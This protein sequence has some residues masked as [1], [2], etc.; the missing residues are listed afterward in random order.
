MELIDLY[1][2]E[3][4]K[5]EIE[6]KYLLETKIAKN[7]GLTNKQVLLNYGS[8][9][10]LLLFFGAHSAWSLKN[11]KRQLKVLLDY[12][13]YFFTLKQLEEWPISPIFIK[14][15]SNFELSI[16]RFIKG[17]NKNNPDIIVVTTPNNPTGKPFSDE[18]IFEVINK[19]PSETLVLIDRSC[20]NYLPEISSKEILN[21]FKTKKIMVMHS[22]SKSHSLSDQRLGYVAS[23]NEEVI[24]FLSKK[25]DLNHN[26]NALKKLE[27]LINDKKIV[28]E[29]KQ[30]IKSCNQLLQKF[31]ASFDNATYF[32]SYSN[33]AIIKLPNTTNS[34]E[35]EAYMLA[36]N[37]LVMGGHKIG[38]GSEYLRV[39]MSGIEEINS[40]I[41]NFKHFCK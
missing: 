17:I 28:A 34:I 29:K 33:F 39:H 7:L 14:R 5:E 15:D 20:I 25:S 4:Y 19:T 36:K 2:G 9:S 31:F 1:Y 40:F 3:N 21:K 12:P 23:N 24:S 35:V 6:L 8:N 16:E 10:N 26:I 22:F 13:N 38:L 30:I 11:N 32:E 37:I 41:E 27:E 18:Q